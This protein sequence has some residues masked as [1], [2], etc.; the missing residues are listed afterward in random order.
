MVS[1]G[2]QNALS[3]LVT[4]NK[5]TGKKTTPVRTLLVIIAAVVVTAALTYALSAIFIVQHRHTIVSGQNVTL[6]GIQTK[7]TTAH[8]TKAAVA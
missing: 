1:N 7:G 3:H 5:W 8:H 4:N 6:F 2:E